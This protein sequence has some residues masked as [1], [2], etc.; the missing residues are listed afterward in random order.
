MPD[1][2]KLVDPPNA[3]APMADSPGTQQQF[4]QPWAA[5]NQQVS[6][7][8]NQLAATSGVGVTDGSEAQPGQIGEYMTMTGTATGLANNAMTPV[9]SLDLTAGDWDVSGNVQFSSGGTGSHLGYY[10]G[11]DDLDT[12]V[13]ATFPTSAIVQ[14]LTTAA[15]RYNIATGETVELMAQASFGGG[16]MTATGTIRARRAR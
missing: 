8:L 2:V 7:L 1:P 6:D 11:I 12:Y 15:R 10:V 16:T 5:Y 4:S 13:V 14:G 9:A 3:H